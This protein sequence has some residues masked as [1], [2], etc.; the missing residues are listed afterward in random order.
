MRNLIIFILIVLYTIKSV[1]QEK[2]KVVFI[3]DKENKEMEIKNIYKINGLT[4]KYFDKKNTKEYLS[5]KSIKSFVLKTSEFKRKLKNNKDS[6][7]E[8]YSNYDFYIFEPKKD[9]FGCLYQVEK[10]WLVEGKT[11]N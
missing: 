3:F 9:S 6:F 8:V 7:P 1:S 10:I 5:F 4:F 2:Q 11:Q